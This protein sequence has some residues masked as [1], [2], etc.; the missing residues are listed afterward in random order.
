M[1]RQTIMG[2]VLLALTIS[3]TLA[4][5]Q[6]VKATVANQDATI[7]AMVAKTNASAA[8]TAALEAD[9]KKLREEC[10]DD[11]AAC[12]KR[13]VR[14]YNA[15]KEVGIND[16]SIQRI[17]DGVIGAIGPV[18][19]V[20][21]G[22]VHQK[23]DEIQATL[24]RIEKRLATPA[25]QGC[26]AQCTAVIGTLRSLDGTT[27]DSEAVKNMV[28]ACEDCMNRAVLDPNYA[29]AMCLK[30]PGAD[31]R[32]RDGLGERVKID[33]HQLNPYLYSLASNVPPPP[34]Y[35]LPDWAM[36]FIGMGAATAG[37]AGAGALIGHFEQPQADEPG[38]HTDG[39]ADEG[40]WIGAL[41][42]A[43]IGAISCGIAQ[44]VRNGE[45]NQWEKAKVAAEA[46]AA[47]AANT[48]IPPAMWRAANLPM[49]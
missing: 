40:A 4:F 15:C 38:K 21:L 20:K 5:G 27:V 12:R 47:A 39:H 44:G 26:A 48:Y 2:L 22:P 28:E 3:G 23:L 16:E 37:G 8:Q 30:T 32:F 35:D 25:G 7:R 33:K 45:R 19:D 49:W 18:L 1:I 34:Q 36:W 24:A 43:G 11:S 6:N 42:G 9:L 17:I 29:L 41:T 31:C 14:V 10:C 46:A 13:K